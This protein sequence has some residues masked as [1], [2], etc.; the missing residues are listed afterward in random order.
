MSIKGLVNDKNMWDSLNEELD[1]RINFYHKQMEILTD[2]DDLYRLQGEI[3][4]IRS[5]KGLRN[6]INGAQTD[7]F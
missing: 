1:S 3:K 4:A 7:T 2:T 6:K 5:L